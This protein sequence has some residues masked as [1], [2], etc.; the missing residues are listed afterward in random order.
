MQRNPQLPYGSPQSGSALSP[1]Q[2]SGA[3]MHAGMGPYQQNNSMG[4]YGPQGA[5]Y[6]PQGKT[7]SLIF[8]NAL[9]LFV[10][11]VNPVEDM[12]VIEVFV[13]KNVVHRICN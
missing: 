13:M 2:S 3:Q 9:H 7:Q 4:N 12:I 5:Q 10:V 6:G 11:K 1:R 8:T